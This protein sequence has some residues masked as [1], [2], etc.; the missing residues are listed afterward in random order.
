MLSLFPYQIVVRVRGCRASLPFGGIWRRGI[1]LRQAGAGG[2]IDTN[3]RRLR[4]NDRQVRFC[5]EYIIDHNATQAAIRAG[6][7]PAAARQVASRL[8]TNANVQQKVQEMASKVTKGAIASAEEVLEH[9]TRVMRG[10]IFYQVVKRDE[11]GKVTKVDVVAKLSDRNKA[12][13]ALAKHYALL[14]EKVEV[15]KPK[16]EMADEI[17]QV[18]AARE[19]D[20]T[21][22]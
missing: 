18:L 3:G 1:F 15:T 17:A 6:Y 19:K 14:V 2:C 4:V 7:S 21:P 16:S 20:V 5:E 8:L 22:S 11:D 10:E 13:E 12:A 9:F